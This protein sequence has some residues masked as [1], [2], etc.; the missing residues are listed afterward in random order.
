MIRWTYKNYDC[1]RTWYIEEVDGA[2]LFG[3]DRNHLQWLLNH[4]RLGSLLYFDDAPFR[5]HVNKGRHRVV[6]PYEVVI[7][8]PPPD[9]E[10]LRAEGN[11]IV[12]YREV[13]PERG[14]WLDQ[15]VTRRW[16]GRT[17]SVRQDARSFDHFPYR[18]AIRRSSAFRAEEFI[19]H[20]EACASFCER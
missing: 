8:S 9:A 16:S 6:G 3:V 17:A 19:E 2:G 11:S 10:V 14:P 7:A 1:R 15:R 13:H 5:H 18:F 12:A 4:V 20:P